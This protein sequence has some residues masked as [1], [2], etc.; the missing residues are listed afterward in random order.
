MLKKIFIILLLPLLLYSCGYTKLYSDKN[1]K[2][3]N[4]EILKIEGD[5]ELNNYISSNLKRF[6]NKDGQKFD[7][8]IVTRYSISDSS[9]NLKGSVSNYQLTSV[10]TFK[11]KNKSFNK[12]IT[13]QENSTM[14]NLSDNFEKKNYE[15]SIKKNFSDST[16]NRLILQLAT[17]K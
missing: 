10:S 3:I 17:F 2:N 4:I 14:K 6:S 11:V 13:I 1:N 15:K 7:L 8:E 9:K 5:Q 12:I 16:V